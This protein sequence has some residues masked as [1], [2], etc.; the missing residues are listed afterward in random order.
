[1]HAVLL[2]EALDLA[3]KLRNVF[4]LGHVRRASMLDLVVGIDD[5]SADAMSHH[6][7]PSLLETA[8]DPHRLVVAIKQISDNGR[9]MTVA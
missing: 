8:V 2:G 3:E 1:M 5:Q 4:G 6:C 9:E 7:R